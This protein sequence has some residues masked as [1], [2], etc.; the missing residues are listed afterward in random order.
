MEK[1]KKMTY[2]NPMKELRL[3]P[4]YIA[5]VFLHGCIST[6]THNKRMTEKAEISYAKGATE[7]ADTLGREIEKLQ[8]ENDTLKQFISREYQPRDSSGRWEKVNGKWV[9]REG[10]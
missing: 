1:E 4:L 7:T 8:K 3:Y 5:L 6:K 9:D 10:K 2:N